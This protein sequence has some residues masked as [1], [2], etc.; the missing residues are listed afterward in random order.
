[1]FG[2]MVVLLVL[3][4]GCAL[5]TLGRGGARTILAGLMAVL[6]LGVGLPWLVLRGASPL[7]VAWPLGLLVLAGL[8][9][10]GGPNRKS[11]AAFL[12]AASALLL[13]GALPILLAAT[14]QLSGLATEFGPR[15]HLDL[16]LL[17]GPAF[18]K[19][20]FGR[21]LLAAIILACLGGVMD[22]A[23]TIA[24][25]VREVTTA[26][27]GISFRERFLIGWRV[28][29]GVLGPM[30]STLLLVFFGSE[31]AVHVARAA[32]PGS[33]WDVVRLSNYE[34]VASEVLA[35]VTAGMGLLCCIPLTA[36]FAAGLLGDK[37]SGEERQRQR[38]SEGSVVAGDRP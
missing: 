8:F 18:G 32:R 31:L 30:L 26:K 34:S 16:R 11:L 19:V 21:L 12:G 24:S 20:A 28:G 17:Y 3:F 35:T 27:E 36:L 33:V 38:N 1:M 22:V 2:S 14:L 29:A 5:L 13:A 9:L 10:I 37:Q 23:M 7:L 25:A 4:L 15:L 6:A